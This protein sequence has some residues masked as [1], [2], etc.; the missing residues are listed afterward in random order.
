VRQTERQTDRER[1]REREREGG[2]G[3]ICKSRF[4]NERLL[5]T[6]DICCDVPLDGRFV[7][8][9]TCRKACRKLRMIIWLTFTSATQ[10]RITYTCTNASIKRLASFPLEV[11]EST[12]RRMR[13]FRGRE[14]TVSRIPFNGQELEDLWD[15]WLADDY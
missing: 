2:G 5:M 7:C 8:E 1:E 9:L 13:A 11:S 15:R 3:G 4:L 6:F 14:V 12:L 10:P